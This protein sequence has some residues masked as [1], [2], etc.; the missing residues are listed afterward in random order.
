LD[1]SC[2]ALREALDANLQQNKN[3]TEIGPK[4]NNDG[5]SSPL[6]LTNEGGSELSVGCSS[7]ASP[8]SSSSSHSSSSAF[9]N[10]EQR[11]QSPLANNFSSSI[12]PTKL[13]VSPTLFSML[14]GEQGLNDLQ[15]VLEVIFMKGNV[16]I[17][18]SI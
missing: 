14:G 8:S 11:Q 2:Q 10:G 3:T 13:A 16:Q 5:H 6:L 15:K 9:P 12:W 7:S 18:I 4:N 1:N 17:N